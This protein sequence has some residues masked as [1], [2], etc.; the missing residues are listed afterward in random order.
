MRCES[1]SRPDLMAGRTSEASR[2]S[3]TARGPRPDPIAEAL[4]GFLTKPGKGGDT[5]RGGSP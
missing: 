2:S 5:K 4:R 1:A 3:D